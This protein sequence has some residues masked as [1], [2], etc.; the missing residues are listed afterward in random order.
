ME[1]SEELTLNNH[2]LQLILFTYIGGIILPR[3]FL[4]C[5]RSSFLPSQIFCDHPRRK[6]LHFLDSWSSS[7]STYLCLPWSY[8][9]SGLIASCCQLHSGCWY[10]A[11]LEPELSL[12]VTQ[13]AA[14]FQRHVLC[15]L[16]VLYKI[17]L[18][19]PELHTGL[20]VRPPQ[21]RAEGDNPFLCP[22]MLC[23]VPPG[24]E[25]Q[26]GNND[27]CSGWELGEGLILPIGWGFFYFQNYSGSDE[28]GKLCWNSV[29]R[30]SYCTMFGIEERVDFS[31][32]ASS[33]L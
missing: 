15:C 17:I 10:S 8:W 19:C 30:A 3:V 23:L 6:Y 13:T 26:M 4:Y 32:A 18:W 11:L 12:Y 20:K 5:L 22:A 28:L 33:L 1:I 21:G 2:L 7:S 31:S 14:Y 16:G 27:L 9:K 29:P 24:S 25:H